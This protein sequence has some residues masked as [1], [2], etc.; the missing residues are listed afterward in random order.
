MQEE[1]A[2]YSQN[3]I[4]R[5]RAYFSQKC[6]RDISVEEAIEYLNALAGLYE[7]FI[8]FAEE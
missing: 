1:K 8:E 5:T 3:L 6:G 7:S 2:T 4:D